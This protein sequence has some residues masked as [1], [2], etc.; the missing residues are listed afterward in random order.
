[1]LLSR[2]SKQRWAEILK[3][4]SYTPLNCPLIFLRMVSS[5]I[6]KQI[7]ELKNNNQLKM[8]FDISTKRFP[9]AV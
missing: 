2:Y 4:T 1:M 3:D 9:V 7:T 6:F 8:P 5:R